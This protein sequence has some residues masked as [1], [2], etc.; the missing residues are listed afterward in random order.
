MFI[1]IFSLLKLI[2]FTFKV[3]YDLITRDICYK[4]V[5]LFDFLTSTTKEKKL[6]ISSIPKYQTTFQTFPK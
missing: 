1:I 3:I 4:L 6:Y 5:V 2:Y